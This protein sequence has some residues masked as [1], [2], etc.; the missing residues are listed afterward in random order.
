MKEKGVSKLD[1]STVAKFAK[2]QNEGGR[3]VERFIE[4]YNLDV[5]ISVDYFDCID[6]LAL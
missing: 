5:I 1:N 6:R 2:V 3:E 4:Y